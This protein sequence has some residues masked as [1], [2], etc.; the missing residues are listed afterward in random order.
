MKDGKKITFHGEGDQEP[1]LK[2]ADI[3]IVLDQKDYAI[4]TQRG[5][6]LFMCMEDIELVEALCGFQKPIST[7][8]N[9]TIVITSHPG[10]TVKH[11]NINEGM[12]IYHRPCEKG[13]LITEFNVNFPE[14]GFLSPDKLSLLEKFLPERK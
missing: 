14:N 4:F 13:R 7:L 12:P 8:H 3:I 9:R 11:E 10:Q 6:D 5:E 1:G 2:P